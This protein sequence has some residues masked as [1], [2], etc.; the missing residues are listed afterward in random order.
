MPTRSPCMTCYLVAIATFKFYH[1]TISKMLTGKM[2]MTL[3]SKLVEVKCKYDNQ[4]PIIQD[5]LLDGNTNSYPIAKI[6]I[7]EICMTIT[8]RMDQGQMYTFHS[9][10]HIISHSLSMV[11]WIISIIVC[12]IIA[13]EL[14]KYCQLQHLIMKKGKVIR[15]NVA[16]YT[17]DAKLILYKICEKMA[18]RSQAV[19]V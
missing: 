10:A 15:N 3:T 18:V 5:L 1:V 6:F 9:K 17:L 11:T 4:N 14:S 8:F 2:C 7:V 13:Y 19:F 12:A 16:N